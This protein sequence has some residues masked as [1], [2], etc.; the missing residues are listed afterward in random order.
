M[1]FLSRFYRAGIFIVLFS[2]SAHT[3][4]E[5]SQTVL[6]GFA[7]SLSGISE[8]FGKSMA[9]AAEL[10]I[11]AAN[12]HPYKI[13][14]KHVLF[15][16]VRVDD[17]GDPDRARH[18][19]N[20][21]VRAG[22]IGVIGGAN[23]TTSVASA[24][25]YAA[26]GIAQISPAATTRKFTGMGYRT[27]FRTLGGDSEAIHFLADYVIDD[28]RA[29]RI[30]VID[31]GT[32]F[33]VGVAAHFIDVAAKN[34]ATIVSHD[35]VTQTESDFDK[36]LLRL[37]AQDIDL[38]FFGGYT[39]QTSMLTKN[40][41]RLEMKTK[42]LTSLIGVVGSSFL[43]S[44]G[45]AANGTFSL[46]AGLPFNKM[47]GW[48]KF[49]AAYTQRFDFNVYGMTPFAYDAAQVLIAAIRQANS[50]DARKVVDVLHRIQ[51]RGLTGTISFDAAGNLRN[52][53]FTIYE[54]QN[55]RWVALKSHTAE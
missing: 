45:T 23:S 40:M 17:Q 11:A 53:S 25:I 52:P 46:E 38:I 19:A 29:S 51:Y 10:A 30:A 2:V 26:A 37:K 13:N 50:L 35:T 22:V 54:V 1:P 31:N 9:N 36:I 4:A 20:I 27:T 18:V 44:T 33:G 42:L 34:G 8:T 15:R 48:K 32:L 24:K 16:L 5:G 12:H 47:P 49:E 39:S 3:C 28:L 55:Q 21:L 43:I 6:I 14:G 41:R 7:G